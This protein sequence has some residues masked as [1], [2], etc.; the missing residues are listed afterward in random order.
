[1]RAFDIGNDA[2]RA[3]DANQ[4]YTEGSDWNETGERDHQGRD[5]SEACH[6]SWRGPQRDYR[7]DRGQNDLQA[8]PG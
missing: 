7:N 1:V 6:C 2:D 4:N 8:I 3:P 5:C